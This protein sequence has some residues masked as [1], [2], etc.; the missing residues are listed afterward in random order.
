MPN[1]TRKADSD[2]LEKITK[3]QEENIKLNKSNTNYKKLAPIIGALGI[4]ISLL[5]LFMF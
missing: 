3:L 4:G 5:T 2:N 1:V